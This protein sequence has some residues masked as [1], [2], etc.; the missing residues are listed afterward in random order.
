MDSESSEKGG[1]PSNGYKIDPAAF[2]QASED[3]AKTGKFDDVKV[4][5]ACWSRRSKWASESIYFLN[6]IKH[7]SQSWFVFHKL[8]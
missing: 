1:E 5:Y 4:E 3:I 7:Q 8:H 6:D 2:I